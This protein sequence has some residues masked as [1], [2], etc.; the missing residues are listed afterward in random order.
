MIQNTT[1]L[2]QGTALFKQNLLGEGADLGVRS[3][4]NDRFGLSAGYRTNNGAF[5][6]A[7]LWLNNKFNLN[8]GF[9]LG[10][11]KYR[12]SHEVMLGFQLCEKNSKRKTF[13][14]QSTTEQPQNESITS[15]P[16]EYS[17]KEI[18]Q[19]IAENPEAE[20]LPDPEPAVSEDM[21]I[22]SVNNAFETQEMLIVFWAKLCARNSL[23]QS[24][25]NY[26]CCGSFL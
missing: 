24:G 21:L 6:K 3:L 25:K 2:V 20:T 16:D 15:Q 22:D 23:Q 4:W 17:T 12:H 10:T 19:V 5:F 14:S 7:E 9:G 26:R 13:T 11:D 18:E 8:Y 1:W